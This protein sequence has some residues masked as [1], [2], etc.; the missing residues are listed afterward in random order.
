MNLSQE[1]IDDMFSIAKKL[2]E[3]ETPCEVPKVNKIP[4]CINCKEYSLIEDTSNG[5][6][7]CTKCGTV[8]EDNIIDETAEWNF[9]ADEAASGGKDPARCGMPVDPYF[10]RSS[11]TTMI[12]GNSKRAFFMKRL[13]AQ[14][15]MDYVERSRYHM[16]VKI[17]KMCEDLCPTIFNTVKHYYVK[18]AEEKLSRGNVRL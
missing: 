2:R 6:V 4:N 8:N 14:I 17:G 5:I 12:G 7:V 16:F 3:K 18:M 13:Q 1:E 9:G 15:S 11:C 10:Q